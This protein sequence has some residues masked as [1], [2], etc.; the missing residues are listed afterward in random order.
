MDRYK[1][2]TGAYKASINNAAIEFFLKYMEEYKINFRYFI[3]IEFS[4]KKATSS[5]IDRQIKHLDNVNKALFGSNKRNVDAPGL[6]YIKERYNHNKREFHLHVFLEEV[7]DAILQKHI[8]EIFL[9]SSKSEILPPVLF[10]EKEAAFVDFY[11]QYLRRNMKDIGTSQDSIKII[12]VYGIDGLIKY[13]NK[14]ILLEDITSLDH[15]DIHRGIFNKD[16]R[17]SREKAISKRISES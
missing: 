4:P 17:T 9:V 3:T 10:T 6:I 12:P 2:D 8:D 16:W 14:S 1:R 7:S 13:G 15:V 11:A 5:L